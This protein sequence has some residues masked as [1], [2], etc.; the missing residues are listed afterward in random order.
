MPCMCFSSLTSAF[1]EDS[2]DS[3]LNQDCEP[4]VPE[5]AIVRENVGQ[6]T[7]L[8]RHPYLLVLG[9]LH[10]LRPKTDLFHSLPLTSDPKQKPT[11]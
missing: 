6:R 9:I 5:M 10:E 3:T 4:A 2:W 7:I 11:F 8:K 1:K